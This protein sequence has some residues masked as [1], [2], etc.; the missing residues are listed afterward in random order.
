[1]VEDMNKKESPTL[2]KVH[3]KMGFCS[4]LEPP[5]FVKKISWDAFIHLHGVRGS[6][7]AIAKD[8]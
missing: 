7:K 5:H 6:N 1:M 3:S 8:R 4:G 2:K